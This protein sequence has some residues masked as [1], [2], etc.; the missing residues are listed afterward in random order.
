M[1]PEPQKAELATTR[2]AVRAGMD[3]NPRSRRLGRDPGMG[4]RERRRGAHDDHDALCCQFRLP[5]PVVAIVLHRKA[6]RLGVVRGSPPVGLGAGPVHSAPAVFG[7]DELA[8]RAVFGVGKFRRD[9]E[10]VYRA[11]ERAVWEA[12]NRS[13]IAADRRG[14]ARRV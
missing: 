1:V 6:A 13:L 5:F 7:T 8:D 3:A 14:L 12:E 2:L 10:F 4:R 9:L 11:A